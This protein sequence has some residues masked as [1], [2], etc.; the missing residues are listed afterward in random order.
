M[1]M[2]L[3]I[4]F[5][6][7]RN[8]R[9]DTPRQKITNV[10]KLYNAYDEAE[11]GSVAKF[12]I[13]GVGSKKRPA[14]DDNL[15][16]DNLLS[17]TFD[18]LFGAGFGVGGHARINS[19]ITQVRKHLKGH[20]DNIDLTIDVFGFSRGAIMA[21]HFVNKISKTKPLFSTN[22]N[23]RFL[24]IFDSVGSFGLPGDNNDNFDHGVDPKLVQ[25]AYHLVAENELR[26][27][28]DLQ[29]I[30]KSPA[31]PLQHN[32]TACTGNRWMVEILCPGVHADIG[33]GY[34][35]IS[36]KK[37]QH[38]N[39]NNYLS[40]YY[41][42]RMY[43]MARKC[44]VPLSRAPEDDHSKFWAY[45][46]EIKSTLHNIL[47]YY[48]RQPSMRIMHAI[49]RETEEHLEVSE[50]E[51]DDTLKWKSGPGRRQ[52]TSRYR[53]RESAIRAIR[54]YGLPALE[55]LFLR[56]AFQN[57]STNNKTF[58]KKYRDFQKA[59]MHKSHWPANRTVAMGAEETSFSTNHPHWEALV[60]YPKI[61]KL[62]R[63]V[64]R[65]IFWNSAR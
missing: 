43:K 34:N 64:K 60:S 3:G 56:D 49:L 45:D 17:Q 61:E 63:T 35:M 11:D 23:I 29:S 46:K 32:D 50:E 28:F 8:N 12:Y 14:D 26:K 27:N 24:G 19:I 15:A 18:E 1:K 33:G 25:Y 65:E 38:G 57:H 5:D 6:G 36:G 37:P 4:F 55:K 22:Q 39:K 41:L 59:Y 16:G 9:H 13:R 20:P 40:R 7:T 42:E 30:R 53:N 44:G 48:K 2:T 54:K 47:A 21:R 10:A 58:L 52:K 62:R 51:L 31:E